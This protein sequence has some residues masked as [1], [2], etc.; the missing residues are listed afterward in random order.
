MNLTLTSVVVHI[1]VVGV[2]SDGSLEI[3][4]SVRVVSYLSILRFHD[5]GLH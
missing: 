2:V 5:R 4:E 3:A 1:R